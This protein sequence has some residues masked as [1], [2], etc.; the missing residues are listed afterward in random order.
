ML[1]PFRGHREQ[2]RAPTHFVDQTAGSA[3][4]TIRQSEY[5][6]DLTFNVEIIVKI[7]L[8][9]SEFIT[10]HEHSAQRTRMLQNQCKAHLFAWFRVPRTVIPESDREVTWMMVGK[11]LSQESNRPIIGSIDQAPPGAQQCGLPLWSFSLHDCV[12][13]IPHCSTLPCDT[14]RRRPI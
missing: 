4:Q 13:T 14:F 8:A 7:R 1:A 6:N 12:T 2:L 3:N 9:Q 11:Q 5:G 10:R